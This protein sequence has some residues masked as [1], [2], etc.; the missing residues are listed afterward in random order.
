MQYYYRRRPTQPEGLYDPQFEHDACG[1]GF[2][3]NITGVKSHQIVQQ[4]LR[5]LDSLAH[6]GATGCDPRTGDGAG[7]LMQ[8]PHEFL[9]RKAAEVGF[10]L[11]DPGEY[12]VG[13]VFLPRPRGPRFTHDLD[14]CELLFEEMVRE[15]GLKVLGWRKV[16]V[17]LSA[18]GDIAREVVPEIRQ[19]FVGRG[20]ATQTQDELERR[21]FLVRKR[22]EKA[23]R[24]E[25]MR[26][27]NMFYICSLSTRRLVYKG[28]LM[29]HQIPEFY[30][31]LSDPTMVSA[32]ALVHARF[33][34]NT[35]PSWDLAQPFRYLGHNGEI[36]TLRGNVN[37][38]HARERLLGSPLFGEDV[39]KLLPIITP[40]GSD[41]AMFD[42]VLELLIQGGRSL[43]HSMMML[44][45]EAWQNDSYMSD[46]KKAFYQYHSSLMEPWDGPAS[47]AFSDGVQIGA[48]LDRN[49]LRP[50]RYVVTKSG[51]VVMASEVGVL[52][53]PP[54]E[55]ASKGRL[56]PGRMFLVDTQQKAIVSDE[57][58]KH[59]YSARRPY[60]TWLNDNLKTLDDLPSVPGAAPTGWANEAN[61][62]TGPIAGGEG[63]LQDLQQAFG[64]TVEDLKLLMTPMAANGE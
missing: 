52:D 2:V 25:D 54:S 37:W 22:V 56:Q 32:L 43:A 48:V 61:G 51:L 8:L 59:E 49:G 36:N 63:Q 20:S 14:R 57:E 35:F 1:V 50:S 47:I 40:G 33:S 64:Y 15:E 29:S 21:L 27:A 58:L 5:V 42:N 16:P 17:E 53:I 3:A 55:I 11:P 26:D 18:C 31:D 30:P 34:T 39:K 6:R 13:M 44:I 23:V 60:R 10:G 41:S 62:A 19:I 12:G 46:E 24:D 4:G 7:I 9:R 45:P 28:L 38:M